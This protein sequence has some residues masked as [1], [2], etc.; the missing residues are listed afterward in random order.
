MKKMIFI[1]LSLF[2]TLTAIADDGTTY[3]PPTPDMLLN[4]ASAPQI[5]DVTVNEL[6]NGG[7]GSGSL[8]MIEIYFNETTNIDG[9]RL[10]FNDSNTHKYVNIGSGLGNVIYPNGSTGSDNQTTYPKGTYIVYTI[11]GIDPTNGEIFITNTTSTLTSGANA[12][13]DYFRYYKTSEQTYY[14]V[15]DGACSIELNS[16]DSNAKDISRLTDGSGDFYQ[17]YPGTTDLVDVSEGSSNTD[18]LPP[19]STLQ[20]NV[21][22]QAD[23]NQTQAYTNNL[24]T[25]TLKIT[26]PSSGSITVTD[27]N[28]SNL[29]PA[30]LSYVSND[31]GTLLDPTLPSN[32]YGTVTSTSPTFIW[33]LING[34]T[35]L[36]FP[37][38]SVSE[39]KIILLVTAAAGTTIT[40]TA[41]L[42]TKQTNLGTT[43]SG[44][45]TINLP[46]VNYQ[47]DAWDSFRS[48]SDRNISTKIV[49]K[50]FNLTIAALNSSGTAFQDFNG[51]VCTYIVDSAGNALSTWNKLLFSST[52]S[53]TSTFTLNRAIGESDSAGIKLYWKNSVDNTCPLANEDNSTLASDRFTVRPLSF[54][55]SAPSA[56]AG[57][58]FNI[59]FTAPN[60]SS[61]PSSDYNETAGSS[62]NLSIAEHNA[63]CPMGTFNPPPDSFS[64][65][66][67]SK[68]FT[69]RYNEVGILDLNITDL[70]EPCSSMYARIDCDDAN[71]SGFYNSSSDLPIGLTQGQITVKPDHFDVNA[72]LTNFNGGVFTYLSDDLNMSASLTM[73]V[74]AKNGEGNTTHN[75]DK[76]CYAKS[77]TLILPHSAVPSPLSQI[78]YIE[79]LS[80]IDG[81]ITKADDITLSFG[82]SIFTQGIAPLQLDFNF[83]RDR[84]APLN[85]FDFN[86]TSASISDADLV[87]NI[88]GINTMIGTAKFVYGR[89]H[90]YDVTNN[91]GYAPNPIEFEIYSTV[92][93]GYVSSMPQN[94]LKWYRNVNHGNAAQG[95]VI[96]GGFNAGGADPAVVPSGILQNG[97][98]MVTV[99][100][101]TDKTVHLDI[102]PWLWYSLTKNYTFSTLSNCTQH[103]CFF[104]DYTHTAEGVKGVNSGTFQGTDFDITPAKNIIKKGVKIFR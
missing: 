60:F 9:W 79:N 17:Y 83:D 87:N 1:F 24:V 5:R 29:I 85:P 72:T 53:T 18:D 28:V 74:T 96:Q 55:I 70:T 61:I 68:I 32:P 76:G 2:I 59:T 88:A 71:V 62:F 26:N 45:I 27:V 4:C 102:S 94:V 39:I 89:V 13:V 14:T 78:L 57:T 91:V 86:I 36:S 64:F 52:Q 104:Y 77:T 50:P 103:P 25:L 93:T 58:D 3:T 15:T 22:I 95:N 99:T 90:A 80:D 16:T 56:I 54:D 43:S 7:G 100:S 84:S 44:T 11:D 21:S 49:D 65:L 66:N 82:N 23:F 42:T 10:Y 69:T 38:N 48:I 8:E 20:A 41:T 37:V 30:G 75:Y 31:G 92:P 19:D 81:N 47:F 98:Q 73:S 63:S 101:S 34:S 51:T 6:F 40:D 46:P 33:R 12:I 35:L 67:G 97:T